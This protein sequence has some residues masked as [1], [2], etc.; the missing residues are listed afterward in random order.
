MDDK[1]KALLY[2]RLSKAKL[3]KIVNSPKR[4]DGKTLLHMHYFLLYC[5]W[6]DT[7]EWIYDTAEDVSIEKVKKHV[8]ATY[9]TYVNTYVV[10]I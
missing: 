8:Q 7:V 3:G 1:S 4:G 5:A 10:S 9:E 6:S 2:A